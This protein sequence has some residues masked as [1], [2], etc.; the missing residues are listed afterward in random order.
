[1]AVLQSTNDL[2]RS[3]ETGLEDGLQISKLDK[4]KA[5]QEWVNKWRQEN[6]VGPNVTPSKDIVPFKWMHPFLHKVQID[7]LQ[8][9]GGM[10]PDL[11][12]PWLPGGQ[13]TDGIPNITNPKLKK[14]LQ[15]KKG[16]KGTDAELFPLAQVDY[17]DIPNAKDLQIR[18]AIQ[19][20][21]KDKKGKYKNPELL[22]RNL[23]RA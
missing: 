13:K 4:L 7:G 2:K 15:Q 23:P 8:I 17:S 19:K 20:Y 6:G 16:I 21:G 14:K 22:I 5:T 9:A 12:T 1:M 10:P 3:Y 18:D 11:N